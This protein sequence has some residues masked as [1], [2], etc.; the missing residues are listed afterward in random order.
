MGKI[1][2]IP[3]TIYPLNITVFWGES[4]DNIKAYLELKH[5][6]DPDIFKTIHFHNPGYT[7]IRETGEIF[8]YLKEEYADDM[9]ILV[10]ECFHATEFILDYVGVI[11]CTESSEAFAYL[12][13][14]I[15]NEIISK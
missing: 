6:N 5:K 8:I 14:Y 4:V 1:L 15:L 12:L 9:G 2:T 11:H 3:A 7:C 10:H 13:Q